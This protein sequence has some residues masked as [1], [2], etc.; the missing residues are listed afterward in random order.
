MSKNKSVV[1]WF[2]LSVFAVIVS[3]AKVKVAVYEHVVVSPE[4][5]EAYFTRQEAFQ[6]MSKN[7]NVFVQQTRKAAEQVLQLICW[8]KKC[9]KFI[10]N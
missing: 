2:I 1:Y 6:W 4:N 5:P 10:D 7:L 8:I 3:C 9:L